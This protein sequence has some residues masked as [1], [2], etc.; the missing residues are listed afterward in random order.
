MRNIWEKERLKICARSSIGKK[1]KRAYKQFVNFKPL[2]KKEK[3]RFENYRN[4]PIK[5]IRRIEYMTKC[6]ERKETNVV[7]YLICYNEN[8][9]KDRRILWQISLLASLFCRS[10]LS[11]V[12]LV[13]C[14]HWPLPQERTLCEGKDLDG[15]AGSM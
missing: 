7:F 8:S 6:P 3:K 4:L 2:S 5:K 1:D 13:V 10:L 15:G 11:V 12:G 9:V 14:T